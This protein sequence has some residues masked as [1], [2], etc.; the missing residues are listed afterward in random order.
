MCKDSQ[1]YEK[2]YILFVSENNQS[3]NGQFLLMQAEEIG[4]RIDIDSDAGRESRDSGSRMQKPPN[5]NDL[6]SQRKAKLKGT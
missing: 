2:Y 4:S 6:L 5:I 1:C 3:C